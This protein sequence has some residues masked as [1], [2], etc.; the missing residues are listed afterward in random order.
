MNANLSKVGGRT[1]HGILRTE[2]TQK[3]LDQHRGSLDE[4]VREMYGLQQNLK[5]HQEEVDMRNAEST[6]RAQATAA[7][8][9]NLQRGVLALEA[10]VMEFAR[11]R[12]SIDGLKQNAER[13]ERV[14]EDTAAASYSLEAEIKR[15]REQQRAG[16]VAEL[17]FVASA[18]AAT[19]SSRATTAATSARESTLGAARAVTAAAVSRRRRAPKNSLLRPPS[20]ARSR[21]QDLPTINPSG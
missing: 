6:K 16:M 15:Q 2:K 14:V 20:V 13:I 3:T 7:T 17:A 19:A 21:S 9:S 4:T 1:E 5:L 10:Q 18:R 12:V 11:M 8:V